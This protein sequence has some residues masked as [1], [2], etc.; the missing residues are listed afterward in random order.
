MFLQ[1]LNPPGK[2]ALQTA[3]RRT[4]RGVGAGLDQVGYGFRLH[5]VQLVIEESPF[6]KFPRPGHPCAE[7]ERPVQ[8]ALQ[9]EGAA[10]GLKFEHILPGVGMRTG[11]VQQDSAIDDV[12]LSVAEIRQRRVTRLWQAAGQLPGD[13][14]N[15]RSGQADDAQAAAA[16]RC[17]NGANGVRRQRQSCA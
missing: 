2:Y 8:Q 15:P 1:G 9:Y 13:V 14:L 12:A 5:Q 10:M 11:E 16:R 3:L 4:R 6:G 17:G 7:F